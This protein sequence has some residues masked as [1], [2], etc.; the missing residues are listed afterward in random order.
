MYAAF[1]LAKQSNF[2]HSCAYA[3]SLLN[4]TI[5]SLTAFPNYGKDTATSIRLLFV[6]LFQIMEK[7]AVLNNAVES[8]TSFPNNGKDTATSTELLLVFFSK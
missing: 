4:N 8:L 3:A 6:F 1:S 2:L 7:K 5:E